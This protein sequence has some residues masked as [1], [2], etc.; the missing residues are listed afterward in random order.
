MKYSAA[1]KRWG[2]REK[3][4]DHGAI[5]ACAERERSGAAVIR[6]GLRKD[7]SRK[8]LTVPGDGA[9]HPEC[10]ADRKGLTG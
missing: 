6:G 5:G 10:N 4:D 1:E 7:L 8:V 3:T 2:C 9:D